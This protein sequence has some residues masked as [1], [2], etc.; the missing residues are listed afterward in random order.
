MKNL[1]SERNIFGA[2]RTRKTG[3][4][5]QNV[6]PA[7]QRYGVGI[8]G[9]HTSVGDYICPVVQLSS[10]NSLTL[11]RV[12]GVWGTVCSLTGDDDAVCSLHL[13]IL[14]LTS[15]RDACQRAI[16]QLRSRVTGSRRVTQRSRQ[17]YWGQWVFY[18]G[19]KLPPESQ[20]LYL[21]CCYS[22]RE[23]DMV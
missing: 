13:V 23:P 6:M 16:A 19:T 17:G 21:D 10:T 9:I 15:R 7:V 12:G 3:R 20:P 2:V 4:K 8:K 1:W 14:L 5:R 22:S 11:S 18:T